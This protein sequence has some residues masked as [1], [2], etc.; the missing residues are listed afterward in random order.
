MHS[1]GKLC[2][3]FATHIH[4]QDGLHTPNMTIAKPPVPKY[5]NS[6]PHG[7]KLHMVQGAKLTDTTTPNA[8]KKLQFATHFDSLVANIGAQ[9]KLGANS[10][11]T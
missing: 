8:T 11:T 5:D 6:K 2:T 4:T 1:L 7:S 9:R 3:I 10:A